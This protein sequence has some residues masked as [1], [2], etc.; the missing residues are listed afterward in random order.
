MKSFMSVLSSLIVLMSVS[1]SCYPKEDVNGLSTG[2]D[3]VGID[4]VKDEGGTTTVD[5]K[6]DPSYTGKETEFPIVSYSVV[7]TQGESGYAFFRIPTLIKSAQ[8][9]LLCFAEGRVDGKSDFGNIDIVLKRSEDGGK[10]WGK[11]IVVKDDGKNRCCNPVPV[12]LENGK[13][14]LVYCWN[15]DGASSSQAVYATF[16][17]DEGLSWSPS[18]DITSQISRLGDSG[19]LTGPVHGIVKQFEPHKGRILIPARCKSSLEKPSHVV[20]SDDGGITWSK[21]SSA[22]YD[23]ENENTIAELANGDILMNMR[24]YNSAIT[25]WFRYDAISSDG[26]DTFS[27]TRMTDLVEPKMGCQ[28]SLL[29]YVNDVRKGNS[30]VLFSNPTHSSSRRYGAVKV[31]YDSGKTWTKMYRYVDDSG[32]GMYSAYSDM[33]LLNNMKTIGVVYEAGQNYTGGIVFKSFDFSSIK[34][35]YTY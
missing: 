22:S 25:E 28:G 21:G 23:H 2:K 4:T 3:T 11:L 30:I 9:D 14:L 32:D 29:T 16:S 33:A 26:G 5:P 15:L 20:Y 34:D 24:N 12:S 35:N 17:D 7:F 8:G 19:Y 31:S 10:T 1:W 27:S 6:T 13:I 18:S